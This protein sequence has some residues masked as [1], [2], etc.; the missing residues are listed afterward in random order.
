M[1]KRLGKG[2]EA[3]LDA[4]SQTKQAY[5][6]PEHNEKK[7]SVTEL[8]IASLVPGVY[9][10]RHH[11]VEEE[12][13]SLASSIRSQGI[14]QPILVR[15]KTANTYEIIAGER[16]WRAAQLAGLKTVPVVI[17]EV[18]DEKTLLMAL[19]E[20]IQRENL[21]ALEEAQ[22]LE[23]LSTQF[24]L[25]HQ[26]IADATGKNRATISNLL[27]LLGLPSEIKILLEQKKLEAGHA[28]ALLGLKGVSQIQVA[29]MIVEKGLSVRETERLVAKML[30]TTSQ[31]SS[32]AH[33]K[34]HHAKDP[35]VLR[36]EKSLSEKLGAWVEIIHDDQEKGKGRITIK[37]NTLDEL[38]G[39]L[40]H[41]Q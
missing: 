17:K 12:L 9:Q 27:R 1:S 8:K 6:K 34:G 16:R 32:P 24:S 23:K 40:E 39:I 15:Q 10:P 20:N 31:P 26:Q 22:A 30:Q 35:D 28:K 13:Q 33:T 29:G 38:E 7:S 19:I 25:T 11:M 36:L 21:N 4:A 3:L 41:I 14:I 18:S 37:Y 2:L 5:S